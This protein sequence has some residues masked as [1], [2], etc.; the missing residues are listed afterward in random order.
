MIVR[1]PRVR[2]LRRAESGQALI[3][4]A[5]LSL[6]LLSLL[7][8]GIDFGRFAYDGILL[9][10]GARAGVQY[11]AQNLATANDDA[12]MQT[13]ATTDAQSL[14]GAS[15]VASQFCTC[16]PGG[17]H[18]TCGT[19]TTCPATNPLVYVSVTTSGTFQPWV[20]FPGIPANL[21]IARTAVMQVS[22]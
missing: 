10:N 20:R 5:I 2:T 19:S 3:E 14:S 13:A 16:V 8:G 21:A 18:V 17:G 9:G 1:L 7:I 6:L 15:A 11:G 4:A 22:P 12:G